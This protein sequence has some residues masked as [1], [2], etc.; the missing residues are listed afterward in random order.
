MRI[1]V[2]SDTHGRTDIAE[3]LI[4]DLNPDYIFHIGDMEADCRRL[5][6]KF[7]RK[8]IVCVNGNNDYFSKA[9]PLERIFTLGGIRFFMCHGHKYNVKASLLPLKLRA[10]EEKADVALFGHTHSPFIDTK[11]D[12]IMLNPG[13]VGSYGIIEIDEGKINASVQKYKQ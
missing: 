4:Q 3:R 13:T 2:L 5:E 12:L 6:E 1:L 8:I 11:E 9:Y 10:L 7:Q